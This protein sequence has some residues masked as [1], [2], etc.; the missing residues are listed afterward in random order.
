M[1]FTK[2][3][4]QEA[5]E[6]ATV[7]AVRRS[8][9]RSFLYFLVGGAVGAAAM[10]SYLRPDVVKDYYQRAQQRIANKFPDNAQPSHAGVNVNLTGTSATQPS[11]QPTK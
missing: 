5:Q 3:Q 7:K 6:K 10:G 1:R 11:T 4:V 8:S 9:T 2:A